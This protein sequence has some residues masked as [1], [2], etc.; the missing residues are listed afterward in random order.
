[1][2]A[3]IL[4]LALFS[5]STKHFIKPSICLQIAGQCEEKKA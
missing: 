4:P 5:I 2:L 1:M 3:A